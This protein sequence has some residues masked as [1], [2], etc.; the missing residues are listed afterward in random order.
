MARKGARLSTCESVIGRLAMNRLEQLSSNESCANLWSQL[1]A[2]SNSWP[3]CTILPGLTYRR[4]LALQPNSRIHDP[5]PADASG[6]VL[7]ALGEDF[8]TIVVRGVVGGSP[9]DEAGLQEG[10][11][12]ETIDGET[13]GRYALWQIQDLFKNS[14]EVKVLTLL[15]RDKRLRTVRIKLRSLA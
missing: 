4:Q 8:K 10:D 12:I 15:K 1:C 14:G 13:A 5:F 11:I 7:K 3:N 2:E 9:A 6:L